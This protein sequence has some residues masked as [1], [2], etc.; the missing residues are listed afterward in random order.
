MLLL[1]KFFGALAVIITIV[2]GSL[3]GWHTWSCS[4]SGKSCEKSVLGPPT[5]AIGPSD[6]GLVRT[7]LQGSSEISLIEVKPLLGAKKLIVAAQTSETKITL[8]VF[9][10]NKQKLVA[11]AEFPDQKK[12]V[13]ITELK[14]KRSDTSVRFELHT[15]STDQPFQYNFTLLNCHSSYRQPDGQLTNIRW[16]QR[17]SDEDSDL[18]EYR[19]SF[20]IISD[21]S[22][23]N[24]NESTYLSFGRY[25]D[26]NG[27]VE[28]TF[29]EDLILSD[30][31][32]R[33]ERQQ[34]RLK[35]DAFGRALNKIDQCIQDS[36][37]ISQDRWTKLC[38]E[39]YDASTVSS[40]SVLRTHVAVVGSKGEEVIARYWTCD[41][42]QEYKL[43]SDHPQIAIAICEDE[44]ERFHDE[45][46]TFV[47]A[48]TKLNVTI[49]P[50]NTSRSH[51]DLIAKTRNFKMRGIKMNDKGDF[52]F[53]LYVD[54]EF[55]DVGG[56][57]FKLPTHSA[58][59]SSAYLT[60]PFRGRFLVELSSS[61]AVSSFSIQ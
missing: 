21:C 27:R 12:Y 19:L 30:A 52:S 42:P 14:R 13:L 61:G 16:H 55:I 10:L 24:V 31:N 1:S 11:F 43:M 7:T 57:T 8:G 32:T 4:N 22:E 37:P 17:S 26:A 35:A 2:L 36:S 51:I 23:I 41:N 40:P 6:V 60:A 5:K 3:S 45:A 28:L 54:T 29:D 49:F 50:I 48:A 39:S 59:T 44:I 25:S 46:R 47:F 34:E 58:G 20:D 15:F 9:N 56:Q 38:V 33:K 18:N 53:D